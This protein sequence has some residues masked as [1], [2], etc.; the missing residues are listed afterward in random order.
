MD[1]KEPMRVIHAA[2]KIADNDFW[3][4]LNCGHV[5]RTEDAYHESSCLLCLGDNKKRTIQE[6]RQDYK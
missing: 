4:L 2:I 5:N 1:M 6:F 3:V